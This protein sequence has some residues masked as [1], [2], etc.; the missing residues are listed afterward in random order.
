MSF[1][2]DYVSLVHDDQWVATRFW[3]EH[4]P[5]KMDIIDFLIYFLLEHTPWKINMEPEDA[6]LEEENHL[7]NNHF[8]VL[9]SSSGVL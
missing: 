4:Q 8:Q 7:Q 3:D 5:G 9:Y 1:K 6:P 2:D